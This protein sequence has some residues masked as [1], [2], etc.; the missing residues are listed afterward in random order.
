MEDKTCDRSLLTQEK[1]CLISWGLPTTIIEKYSKKGIE[2]MFPWQ[3]EC[4]LCEGVL[5]GKNLV[6]SAPTSAGKTMVAEIITIQTVLERKKKVIFILPFISVVREKMLYFQNLLGSSGVRVEGFMGSHSPPGGLRTVHI[7][8]CTIEKANSLINRLLEDQGLDAIG[9]VVVDELHLLGD[10]HRGYLLELLLTKIKY[11]CRKDKTLNI[12]VVG[13]SATLPNVADLAT[14][15]DAALYITQFRPIPLTEYL[16]INSSVYD[17]ATMELKYNIQPIAKFKSDP[18]DVIHLCLESL[19]S[20]HSVVVFC[21][22]RSWCETS[23][24]QIAAEFRRIGYEKSE[25]GR[26][27]R[28]QLDGA[29]ISDVLEQLKRCPA[30]LDTS[31]GRSV[32]FGVAFHHAGLTM[33]ERDIVEGAFRSC[34]LRVLVATSTLSSGV[35]LPARRVLIRCPPRNMGCDVRS[36][37]Q[38]VGRAGRMGKDTAGESFLI[39]SGAERPVGEQ[40]VKAQLP[41]VES[42]LG[43]GDLSSSLKRAV[44]EVIASGVVSTSE[45]VELYT[46][47]TFLASSATED[48]DN[49]LVDPLASCVEYLQ[50]NE[51]IRVSG[52]SL[53]PTPLAE[54]CLSASLPPDQG[55]KLL[56][57]LHRARQCFVL[58]T[59]LHV[60]YQVTPYSVSDQWGQLD[61]LR[62]LSLWEDLPV[63]MKRVGELVGVE[64][65]FLVGAVRG[66][67]NMK[68]NGQKLSIHRRFYTAL[69]LQDLV[70]EVPLPQV[71]VKFACSKGVLQSLQQSASTFAGMVTQFTRRLGWSN[72]E[73]LVS[74]FG[75]RLQFGAQ[76]ELLDLL[77]LD[78]LTALQARALYNNG[79][80]ALSD[81]ATATVGKVQRALA[82]A[83]PFL[84]EQDGEGEESD[85]DKCRIWLVGRCAVTETQAAE[86]LVH[87]ARQ[88][89]ERELGLQSANWGD[90]NASEISSVSEKSLTQV[91]DTPFKCIGQEIK[92]CSEKENEKVMTNKLNTSVGENKE[93]EINNS[94]KTNNDVVSKT[95]LTKC[96]SNIDFETN[97][98]TNTTSHETQNLKQESKGSEDGNSN[99]NVETVRSNS[100]P[101]NNSCTR[102]RGSLDLFDSPDQGDNLDDQLNCSKINTVRG[103]IHLKDC[104]TVITPK[105]LPREMKSKKPTKSIG[106]LEHDS[107]IRK[108]GPEDI[109]VRSNAVS[110]L[111]IDEQPDKNEAVFLDSPKTTDVN[112]AL[113]EK[114]DANLGGESLLEMSSFVPETCEDECVHPESE[115]QNLVDL[116]NTNGEGDS[117]MLGISSLVALTDDRKRK[118]SIEDVNVSKK[119]KVSTPKNCDQ[120][121]EIPVL[122][123]VKVSKHMKSKLQLIKTSTPTLSQSLVDSSSPG[124][125]IVDKQTDTRINNDSCDDLFVNSNECLVNDINMNCEN[126]LSDHKSASFELRVSAEFSEHGSFS[127]YNANIDSNIFNDLDDCSSKENNSTTSSIMENIEN[128]QNFFG[129]EK[130]NLQIAGKDNNTSIKCKAMK[131][132]EKHDQEICSDKSKCVNNDVNN[133]LFEDSFMID[134]K[135]NDI[136]NLRSDTKTKINTQENNKNYSKQIEISEFD[137]N[138]QI[139][140]IMD[141]VETGN[142]YINIVGEPTNGK[143]KWTESMEMKEIQNLMFDDEETIFGTPVSHQKSI[144]F[145]KPGRNK[146]RREQPFHVKN[147]ESQDDPAKVLCTELFKHPRKGKDSK[148]IKTSSVIP[149]SKQSHDCITIPSSEETII[150]SSLEVKQ[151]KNKQSTFDENCSITDSLL[152]KAFESSFNLESKEEK[153]SNPV[154]PKKIIGERT[155]NVDSQTLNETKSQVEIVTVDNARSRREFSAEILKRKCVSLVITT[156]TEEKTGKIGKRFVNKKSEPNY[157]YCYQGV[158]ITSAVICCGSEK[159]YV[160]P[161]DQKHGVLNLSA[162]KEMLG[163]KDLVVCCWDV[164]RS[165]LLLLQCC[166]LQC[167]ARLSD[168]TVAEWLLKPHQQT[169]TLKQMARSY[170][171]SAPQ[172]SLEAGFT[173]LLVL[174]LCSLLRTKLKQCGH[175]KSYTGNTSFTCYQEPHPQDAGGAG[176]GKL[177]EGSGSST[178]GTNTPTPPREVEM[179]TQRVLAELEWEGVA[180]DREYAEL[181]WTATEEK[182]TELQNNLY[183]LCGKKF[184]LRSRTD[185]A[186]AKKMVKETSEDGLDH[187]NS[188]LRSWRV[189]NSLK[190]RNMSG[191]LML[192]GDRIRGCWDSHS[193]T[194]R[195]SMQEPSLQHTP[196]DIVIDDQVFSPRS[197]FIASSG[198]ILV[199]ADFSQ[200]ELRLLAHFS[201]DS[202]L[203]E[204]FNK[205]GD[206]FTAIAAEWNNLPEEQVGAELRHR[207]KQLCYGMI[208]GMGMTTLA[209]EMGVE[210]GKAEEMVN[211]F[212]QSYPGLQ[213]YVSQCVAACRATASCHVTTL[214]GRRRYL[215]DINSANKAL[216]A[217]AER[218]AV[219]TTIQGSAADIA[220]TAML[221]VRQAARDCGL[222]ARL[223]IHLHDELIYEVAQPDVND[224]V[225][226]LR[227][228]ME[229]A[230]TLSVPLPVK[231]KKGHSWGQLELV[232]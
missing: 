91:L 62:V 47:C 89:L 108:Q 225:R 2:K 98:K 44:L 137:I 18:G 30:G 11:M 144:L 150:E 222:V 178:R 99:T 128:K 181:L 39:C 210:E 34:V 197:A 198:N 52:S 114:M 55:L 110:D 193:V 54:A 208:Y 80:Q 58:E 53:S 63:S 155:Q 84:S 61:W 103:N 65:R 42:S 196:R 60:I 174:Q 131:Q 116:W 115:G 13:M 218:Q 176:V 136:I 205:T 57:E 90:L 117:L 87:E 106:A 94:T 229:G 67:L 120:V 121:S 200:L 177:S 151:T 76:R 10:P 92:I 190:T 14:W 124:S 12:Q 7:A 22:T 195:I 6:Y 31:L 226:V 201:Q 221:R 66:T 173:A 157:A 152:K 169:P 74:Q 43:V 126:N 100:T 38:M 33:D 49:S 232:D 82:R 224:F 8:V 161:L 70:N 37:R 9:C 147:N 81:L 127:E 125:P 207:T 223:I 164:K 158:A 104:T 97:G 46:N 15:L 130:S 32:A 188:I 160:V 16:K 227:K 230:V 134:S 119:I 186:K 95:N 145:K 79:I 184:N 179:P 36:Y 206:V 165:L 182:M 215:P 129:L 64:E 133:S 141:N 111:V 73:L 69:A 163:R 35:N 3:V 204:A 172:C 167:E 93:N 228:G 132:N 217:Q 21:P 24:Q 202:A 4:L 156:Q 191:L 59:E 48:S 112:D 40:L 118:H 171:V 143:L 122:N 138:T 5:S 214:L 166:Q 29:A 107:L 211:S 96:P 77:R 56:K 194:G 219:N 83:T 123:E 85:T 175:Y 71:A 101:I 27:V 113:L 50:T 149:V 75:A 185:L 162:L 78:C 192:E 23:A 86:I 154:T 187:F 209:E 213:T 142:N 26:A 25:M 88:Y 20:G 231:V 139:C 135:L 17:A 199:S 45:D 109:L 41:P 140:N 28:E 51:F 180:W 170:G 153:T 72:V 159:M 220:K 19:L 1:Q 189:L 183:T 216:R 102:K 212:H 105:I 68:N 148:A 146:T 203:L 168:P